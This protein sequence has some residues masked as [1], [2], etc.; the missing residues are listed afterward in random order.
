MLD[1]HIALQDKQAVAPILIKWLY[2]YLV[3]LMLYTW[4]IVLLKLIYVIRVVQDLNWDHI[5]VV[6]TL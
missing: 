3:R 2:I 4:I 5:K 1:F 6:K